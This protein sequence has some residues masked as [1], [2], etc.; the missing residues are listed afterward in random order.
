MKNLLF[1]PPGVCV[2]LKTIMVQ[3]SVADYFEDAESDEAKKLFD[4]IVNGLQVNYLCK[5]FL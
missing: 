1:F 4:E 3:M 5:L 2:Q